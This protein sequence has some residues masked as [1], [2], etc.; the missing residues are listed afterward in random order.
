MV[1]GE[2]KGVYLKASLDTTYKRL[3]T[4]ACKSSKKYPKNV[5][6]GIKIIIFGC[7]WIESHA[8]EILRTILHREISSKELEKEIWSMLKRIS[9]EEKLDFFSKLLPSELQKE[10]QTL[11]SPIKQA[12]D[13]R[14]RLAHY[15]NEPIRIAEETSL[16]KI[17]DILSPLPIPEINQQ[18]MWEKI[19]THSETIQNVNEWLKKIAKRYH[20]TKNITIK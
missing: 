4:S 14:G 10:Y 16:E 13:L 7:F 3:F 20:K 8:N 1:K 12:Y 18:L 2:I 6:H 5:A 19:S 17:V 11:K 9:I 15:K